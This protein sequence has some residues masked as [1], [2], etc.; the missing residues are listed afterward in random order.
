[1][2]AGRSDGVPF[3]DIFIRRTRIEVVV[4]FLA[5]LELAKQRFIKLTQGRRFGSIL[6]F[7]RKVYE[8]GHGASV[9]K[10]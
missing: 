3:E 7:A 10:D 8:D 5:V 2:L 4:T 6:I 1:M 9:A